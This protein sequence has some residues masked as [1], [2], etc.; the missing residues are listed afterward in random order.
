MVRYTLWS[1]L[2]AATRATLTTEKTSATNQTYTIAELNEALCHLGIL[3]QL[4][5]Q[6]QAQIL[7]ELVVPVVSSRTFVVEGY[8]SGDREL[9]FVERAGASATDVVSGIRDLVQFMTNAL[10]SPLAVVTSFLSSFSEAV[11]QQ[12]LKEVIIPSMPHDLS[13]LPP[14]LG[15]VEQCVSWEQEGP[16]DSHTRVLER[17]LA[18]QAGGN[19]LA[20]HRAAGFLETRSL[21]YEGWKGWDFRL[22]DT[23]T[24]ASP[25]PMKEDGGNDEGWG[26]DDDLQ[27]SDPASVSVNDGS[28]WDFDDLATVP[29]NPAPAPLA[30][31]AREAKRLGKKLSSKHAS[32]SASQEAL[33]VVQGV[34]GSLPPQETSEPD[35]PRAKP[36]VRASATPEPETLVS[37]SSVR[38]SVA[39][40]A[41]LS[42]I[43]T[44]LLE[45]QKIEDLR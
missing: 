26:F 35:S 30:K 33:V 10:Y 40:D 20:G 13:E 12:V 8:H 1:F 23:K 43:S 36:V 31:P 39:T 11:Y 2:T 3:D 6:L 14:W 38:V 22:E 28:G 4:L 7:R 41:A 37:N 44:R 9:H 24:A 17:F 16:G 27:P 42:L 32:A 19:W 18:E 45:L 34:Q 21:V 15:D 25:P 29:A 5:S